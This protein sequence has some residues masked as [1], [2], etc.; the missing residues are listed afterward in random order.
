MYTAV[1]NCNKFACAILIAALISQGQRAVAGWSGVING[2]GYGQTTVNVRAYETSLLK[3][4]SVGTTNMLNPSAAMTTTSGYVAGATLP[5]DA[6]PATVAKVKGFPGYIWDAIT[7]GSDG[8]STDS[9]EF[10]GVQINPADC[11][12]LEMTSSSVIAPDD[13]SG[14]I[15][16]QA[17]ATAGTGLRVRGYEALG[18]LPEDDPNTDVNETLAFLK[19]NGSLKWDIILL[20]PFNLNTNNCNALVI[21]FTIETGTTNLY[22]ATD[23]V[24]KSLPLVI[25]CPPSFS[26]GCEQS[27]VYPP[28]QFA[29][30]GDVTLTYSPENIGTF[31]PGSFPVGVTPVT[32]TATDKDGN[33]TNCTFTVTVTDTTPPVIP[34]L[35][36]LT[37]ESS[38]TVPVPSGATDNCGG[39]VN[40]S[41]TNSL[42]YTKQGTYTVYWNFDDGNLNTN[43]V[44]QTVIVDDVTPPLAPTI[45]DASGQCSVTVTAPTATD[46]VVGSV[47]GTTSDPLSYTT[48]GTYKITWTFDDGNGNTST[49]IQKVIVKDTIPPVVPT[50]TTVSGSCGASVTLPIPTTTDNCAGTVA[51][52]TTT[53]FP[54]TTA[55]TTVVTWTFNDGNGNISAASQTVIVTGLT[56]NGFYSPIGGTGGSCKVPLRTANLG[57]NLPVKF[58]ETCG[59]SPYLAGK[60]TLSIEKAD[61][62]CVLTLVAAVDFTLV[63]NEWHFN[64]DT[65]SGGVT[66][67]T[68]KL[69]ATLQDGSTRFVWIKLK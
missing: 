2:T 57:N 6:S 28:V 20:G 39:T 13:K 18:A 10:P 69:T 61:A 54:I 16:V 66:R 14:T 7:V 44:P 60:P 34:T 1:H 9:S 19:A 26:V 24:A 12:S 15:T 48:Q 64:W 35:Q 46:N 65:G 37:G 11:A 3:T 45:P 62:D 52:T 21:P 50:L 55:G 27:F 30:C 67:G 59:G 56:F 58:D 51:G 47:T 41:T 38:V 8:D 40:V 43:T 63:G 23:G 4:K 22:F 68:Y 53:V 32:V 42:T 49:A 29:G 31:P 33:K 36:T 25:T 17:I 5:A